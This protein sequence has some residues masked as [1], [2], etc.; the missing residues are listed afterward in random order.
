MHPILFS[1]R[2]ALRFAILIGGLL[3][4]ECLSPTQ[5]TLHLSTDAQCVDLDAAHVVVGKLGD[6]EGRPPSAST[7]TCEGGWIGDLVLVPSKRKDQG[8]GVLVAV[9]VGQSTEQCERDRFEGNCIVARRALSFVP[10]TPI[11]L[12]IELELSCVGVPCGQLETCRHGKC[13]DALLVDP[14]SCTDPLGCEG[15]GGGETTLGPG[16]AADGDGDSTGGEGE[17]TGGTLGSGGSSSAG[18]SDGSGGDEPIASGGTGASTATGGTGG[19]TSGT[20]ASIGAGGDPEPFVCGDGTK[21]PG[22]SC[23]DNNRDPNDGCSPLCLNEY[24]MV[25][26]IVDKRILLVDWNTGSYVRE[27]TNEAK[28][29]QTFVP[30]YLTQASDGIVYV[31]DLNRPILFELTSKGEL[32]SMLSLSAL[33]GVAVQGNELIYADGDTLHRLERGTWA[34]NGTLTSGLFP[35]GLYAIDDRWLVGSDL[36]FGDVWLADKTESEMNQSLF[37]VNATVFDV[38]VTADGRLLVPDA[39]KNLVFELVSSVVPVSGHPFGLPLVQGRSVNVSMGPYDA[40]ELLNGQWLVAADSGLF[41][42]DPDSGLLVDTISLNSMRS[43]AR[44][45]G[46]TVAPE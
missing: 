6:L 2:L 18:G 14:Q 16:G 3:S 33:F 10:H 36:G 17:A 24:L 13:V 35:L 20:G 39:Y 31:A 26:D 32:L 38:S 28:V 11:E 30:G 34:S 7:T 42:Y 44:Y 8:F 40:Y 1:R 27:V 5:V 37:S 15:G 9:G 45:D 19:D 12:P 25:S 29:G 43:I 41:T 22:E 23:D 46:P 4:L 21:D